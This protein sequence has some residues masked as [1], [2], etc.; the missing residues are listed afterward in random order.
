MP[1]NRLNAR[2]GR[3]FVDG[4]EVTSLI[5][6]SAVFVPEVTKRRVVGERGLTSKVIGYDITGTINRYKNTRWLRTAIQAYIN[7]GI[8]PLMEIQAVMDDPDSDL[9]QNFGEDRIQLLNV[10]LDGDL[11]LT[12]ID[13]EGEEVNEEINFSASEV[14]FL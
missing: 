10:Q 9:F 4:E 3:A 1:I 14:R 7:T 6:L 12:A 8:F 11:P 5:A 13:A 2:N